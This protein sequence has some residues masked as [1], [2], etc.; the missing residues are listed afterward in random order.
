M[1]KAGGISRYFSELIG[2]RSEINVQCD[3]LFSDNLYVDARYHVMKGKFSKVQSISNN[4]YFKYCSKNQLHHLSYYNPS[5][6]SVNRNSINIITVYDF[7]H[8]KIGVDGN[9]KKIIELKKECIRR[10]DKII[11]ISKT[12]TE[13]LLDLYNVEPNKV[14]TIYLG[15]DQNRYPLKSTSTVE[16]GFDCPYILFVGS[17]LGYKNFALLVAAYAESSFRANGGKLVAFGGPETDFERTLLENCKLTSDEVKFLGGD[18]SVLQSVYRCA[19]LHIVPS[20]YEGF[21]LTPFESMVNDCKT[22]VHSNPV[23]K[24][25]FSSYEFIF[26]MSTREGLINVID[27]CN[28]VHLASEN[29]RFILNEASRFTWNR[30]RNLTD[31]V[32]SSF[33]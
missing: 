16:I 26:D 25:L 20:L 29:K 31:S 11:S 27:N 23:F 24:E 17:R 10:A 3:L 7:I 2:K 6:F 19:H 4:L 5:S 12:T 13:D 30:M 32:Y 15:V 21:G 14:E 22:V 9:D 1:Q 28:L 18:D 8:E 33:S